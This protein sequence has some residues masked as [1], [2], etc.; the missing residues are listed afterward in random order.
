MEPLLPYGKGFSVKSPKS[1]KA[2]WDEMR[3]NKIKKD[4]N[5][6]DNPHNR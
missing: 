5:M 4:K 3:K 6:L 2:P 1:R